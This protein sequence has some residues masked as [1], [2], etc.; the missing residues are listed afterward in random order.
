MHGF[1]AEADR[2]E[3]LGCHVLFTGC[4]KWL[5]GP[6]G[7]GLVWATQ[8]AWERIDPL[9]PSFDFAAYGAWLRDEPPPAQPAGAVHSP[10]GFHAFELRWALPEAFAF[11]EEIGR[12]R[13]AQRLQDLATRLKS[14]L[15]RTRGVTLVT[16][17]DPAFSA[18]LVCF[19]VDRMNAPAVVEALA[20]RAIVATVTPYA[21]EH[22]RLGV[23]IHL[24]EADVDAAA[25]AVAALA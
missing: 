2:P 13:I 5:A 8:G 14:A 9:V 3:D 22:V 1:G 15:A 6:R 21:V 10:G 11:H 16:P 17:A 19:D 24:D 4:H 25:S 18:G 7:T 20:G 12:E 23:G